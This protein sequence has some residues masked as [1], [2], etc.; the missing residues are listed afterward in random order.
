MRQLAAVAC[1]VALTT[2]LGAQDYRVE[3]RLVEIEVRVTDRSGVPVADLTPADFT[4][5]EN[6][7][8]HDVATAQ[9]LPVYKPGVARWESADGVPAEPVAPGPA[10][11]TWI[12][13]VSEVG[14]TDTGRAVDALRTFLLDGLRPGFRVSIGGRPF[15]EDRTELL[16]TLNRLARG[17]IGADGKPG[18]VDLAWQM[19]DDVA[20][21]RSMAATFKRQLDGF[22]PMPG[23]HAR[24]ESVDTDGSQAR[25]YLTMGRADRQLPV[26]GDVRLNQYYDLVERLAPLPGKKAVVLMRPGLRLEPDNQGMMQDLAG[27]AVRRRVAFYTV[28]SRGLSVKLPTEERQI[29]FMMDRRRRPGE[30]DMVGQVEERTLEREGLENLAR[31]TGGRSLIGTNRLAD[32]FDRVSEDASGYY[33][34]SYYPVDQRQ[35]G[36]FRSVKVDVTRSG[37]K[38]QQQTR[39][40]YETRPQSMFTKDDRGLALRRA[41]QMDQPPA[42]LPTAAS[43]HYFASDE[44]FPVLILS[45]GV[46][47]AALDARKEKTGYQLSATAIV[48]VAD[49]GR[50]RLPMYFERRLDAPVETAAIDR[51]KRDRTA[52]VSMSD[53]LPLL[54]GDYDWRVVFRDERTG[55]M[56][57]AGGRVSLRDF[58]APSIA[59]TLLL[60]RDVSR[61][62]DAAAMPAADRNPLD[63]GALRFAPQ[64]SLV[65][66]KG[67]VVHLLYSLYNAT[68]EDMAEARKGMQLALVRGGALVG[69]VE[70]VGEPL[71]DE[72]RGAIQFT[73]A[74]GTRGLEP[75]TYTVVGLLPNR[76]TRERKQVEQH[77]LLIDPL[78]GS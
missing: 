22:A 64:P 41:M 59:S 1:V 29:P 2:A 49:V 66:S 78:A 21:E 46:P 65:F 38:V 18:I 12:Y 73:G 62:P 20:E 42:D 4:L 8:P 58:R 70:A 48:R 71:V 51:V 47:A 17:P 25:P 43:V 6:D 11:P 10:T 33:V 44:G 5:R 68:P 9:F 55:K 63:A 31:E 50:T 61:L 14:A 76:A 26:Y 15:T 57:G 16:G 19:G 54:P 32:I 13:V 28:D 75:G 40:Y 56:G 53:L 7:I 3:V 52:F 30:P 35:A 60:T 39:G 37:A 27:F 36:R 69:G 77:F 45:A 23:F 67:E 72:G 24:V 34:V 74:I